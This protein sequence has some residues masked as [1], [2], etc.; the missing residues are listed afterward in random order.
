MS[1]DQPDRNT[2]PTTA[3]GL[4]LR[5]VLAGLILA[6]IAGVVWYMNR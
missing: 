2:H 5:V 3:Q 6:A 4:F 1:H